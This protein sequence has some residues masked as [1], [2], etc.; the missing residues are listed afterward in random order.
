M[1]S[2]SSRAWGR[3]IRS[4]AID[5]RFSDGC[6]PLSRITPQFSEVH[7]RRGAT[8][9]AL[10][11]QL[12]EPIEIFLSQRMFELPVAD[13]LADDFAGRRVFASFDCGLESGD[14]L[15]RQRD[16]DLIDIRHV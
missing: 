14:L 15:A 4:T 7:R 8:G 9:N 11:P 3:Q 6:Q 5:G 16:A 1:T 13:G 2:R 12:P 10:V